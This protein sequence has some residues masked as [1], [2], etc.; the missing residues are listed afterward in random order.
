MTDHM[1]DDN[2]I[3]DYHAPQGNHT[4]QSDYTAYVTGID[5]ISL[6]FRLLENIHWILLSAVLFGLATGL[7]VKLFVTPLY[8]ATSK[9]YIAGSET[10]ISLSD[11]QLGSSLAKDYQEVFKIWHVHEM[12]DE[13]LDL[14]YSYS[15]LA[16]M[17]SIS[18]PDGSHLLYINVES[19]DPTEA[20]LLADTYA[21][22]VQ[23]FISEKM[24]LRKPQLLEVAQVPSRPISPNLKS[25]ILKAFILG[26]FAAAAVVAFIFLLDDK[27]RTSE[28]VEKTTGL[29]TFGMISRQEKLQDQAP[30]PSTEAEG[31]DVHIAEIR[32]N[33]S[34]DYTGEEAI[35][36]IISGIMFTG[37]NMKRI[38]LTSYEA[39]NGKTF[40]A[41]RLA[42]SMAKRG[43]KVLLIDGDLR[44]SVLVSQYRIAHTAFGLA[45]YLAGQCSLE[46]AI[47]PTNLANLYLLPVGE[48]VKTPLPLLSSPD[49]EQM[50]DQVGN[51]FDLVIVDTPPVGIVIDAAEIARG[52]DGSLLIIEYNKQS[53]GSLRF[54]QKQMEQ[55]QTPVI[56]CVINDVV[57]KKLYQKQYYYKYGGYYSYYGG[58]QEVKGR[59]RKVSSK[60]GGHRK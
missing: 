35:N 26:A 56:G 47:Y 3:Q 24:E 22:V 50:M 20:K 17:V 1:P 27:I 16:S 11:I 18:N 25:S 2:Q 43:K 30:Y 4:Q 46:D 42:H 34:L 54:M 29:A 8:K 55:T 51:M 6:F 32:K 57:V 9:I 31:E 48:L 41:I 13:R 40:V 12:V 19:S 58:D 33:L 28:D 7:Y 37:K 45:H 52:C 60:K 21:E 59:N 5:W 14:D 39:N 10:T 23:E 44:K 53:K 15:K 36:T 49:F 38:A